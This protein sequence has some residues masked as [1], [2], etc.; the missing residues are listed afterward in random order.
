MNKIIPSEKFLIILL[1]LILSGCSLFSPVDIET[2]KKYTLGELPPCLPSEQTPSTTLL[3]LPPETRPLYNTTQMAYTVHPH[4]IAFFS[5]NEWSETPSQMLY[6]LIRK[7][8][9][10]THYFHAIVTPPYVGPHEYVLST[11]ILELQQDYT[12]CPATLRLTLQ[13]QLS[14][15]TT[16]EVITIKEFSIQE[17]ILQRTPYGGVIAANHAAAKILQQLAEFVLDNTK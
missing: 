12:L 5:F 9:E 15:G 7:T 16:H 6:P 14:H 2:P 13:A 8:L 3:V 11:Q 10:S 1:A 17:P 4:Q